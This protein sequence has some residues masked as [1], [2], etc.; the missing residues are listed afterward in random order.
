[1]NDTGIQSANDLRRAPLWHASD[2]GAPVPDSPDACSVA[3]PLWRHVVGYEEG[4]P[5]TLA[6]LR[7]GYPRFRFHPVVAD[8]MAEAGRRFAAK[9]EVAYVFPSRGAAARC[10][11][12]V[13][14]RTGLTF[15]IEPIGACGIHAVVGPDGGEAACREYWQHTGEIV[16]SRQARSALQRDARKADTEN[17]VGAVLRRRIAEWYEASPEDVFLFPSGMASIHSAILLA[18]HINP[19]V[20]R[21]QLEFPY[22]DTFKLHERFSTDAAL[23]AS[24]QDACDGTA[25]SDI[26]D[27]LRHDGPV[28]IVTTEVP[29]NPLLRTVDLAALSAVLREQNA[30]L[31][32]DDTLA[33]PVN[34]DVTP[35]ADIIATSLTKF[36]CGAGDVMA[37]A[38]VLVPQSPHYDALSEIFTKQHE[39]LLWHEDAVALEFRSRDFAARVRKINS[40]A[41]AL[42][43]H[44]EKHPAVETVYFPK[45]DRGGGYASMM[46]ADGGFGGLISLVPKHPE[47]TAA[48]FYDALAVT[49]G[50]S[51]GTNY[52]L[53][54]PYTMIAHYREL[55]WAESYGVSRWLIRVSVGLEDIDDLR[56]R[57]DRA[58]SVAE[59]AA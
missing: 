12:Y 14:G 52:T 35:W 32:V 59:L 50:P 22:L 43:E 15:R 31:I 13:L 51:L 38:A 25:N 11:D 37:G 44:L 40:T 58:L 29:S 34:V 4:D 17:H 9:K 28:G 45:F 5:A 7:A 39:D 36:F 19:G 42:A 57:F 6:Q 10:C 3:L 56:D 16:S 8:L 21:A 23:Y 54:C 26:L 46:R 18:S 49:K 47:R 27:R 41:E 48:P 24:G 53:A 30:V 55:D 2:L 33:T 20:R 1:M